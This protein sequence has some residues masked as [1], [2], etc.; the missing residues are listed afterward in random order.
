M[1]CNA[2]ELLKY[3]IDAHNRKYE[4]WQRD[5]LAVN[6]YSRHVM[7]QKLNYI[8]FNPLAIHCNLA[9]NPWVYYYSSASFYELKEKNF[10]FLKDVREEC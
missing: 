6:L 4:F 8:H 7:H 5:S 9:S 1:G 2:A 10:N 3:A